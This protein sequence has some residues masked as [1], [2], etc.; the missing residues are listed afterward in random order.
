MAD[1][2]STLSLKLDG[3]QLSASAAKLRSELAALGMTGEQQRKFFG[4]S[5]PA[6]FK[7]TEQ[8]ANRVTDAMKRMRE[9]SAAAAMALQIRGNDP[10]Q[11]VATRVE[12]ANVQMRT[13]TQL[14]K[15]AAVNTGVLGRQG[16]LLANVI[17]ESVERFGE[18]RKAQVA[19]AAATGATVTTMTTLKAAI[20][21]INP[22]MGILLAG[23]A[24]Y[25]ITSKL[26]G[27][28]TD[29]LVEAAERNIQKQEKL[30]E[31]L[32]KQN[33]EWIA[34]ER[35]ASN[36]EARLRNV[37]GGGNDRE[38]A[39]RLAI[40]DR[41]MESARQARAA[42]RNPEQ[43]EEAAA[44]THNFLLREFNASKDLEAF[45]E[46]QGRLRAEKERLEELKA[47][48]LGGAA[49]VETL[50]R[51]RV[52]S[53]DA[54]K[55][56]TEDEVR[57][58]QA[59]VTYLE[60]LKRAS[61][62]IEGQNVVSAPLQ[63]IK[64]DIAELPELK[65]GIMEIRRTWMQ[66]VGDSLIAFADGFNEVIDTVHDSFVNMIADIFGT[67]VATNFAN[68]IGSALAPVLTSVFGSILTSVAS[69]FWGWLSGTGDHTLGELL[70]ATRFNRFG[71]LAGQRHR[72][73]LSNLPSTGDDL[74]GR[75]DADPFAKGG[76]KGV[77]PGAP[78]TI[79]TR[80]G[81]G[82]SIEQ[83]NRLIGLTGTMVALLRRIDTSTAK[84]ANGGVQLSRDMNDAANRS[85]Y[86]GGDAL[87][88]A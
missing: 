35:A 36:A 71:G 76:D 52:L 42:G 22:V 45:N 65:A 59:T 82:A 51:A 58:L 54:P 48:L 80:F 61:A 46:R 67:K 62:P 17:G 1:A 30:T 26:M 2:M 69:D 34:M 8:G 57:R 14:T 32:R 79:T 25:T 86:L 60:Q 23:M 16:F 44:R 12:G 56:V 77:V 66:T 5:L 41:A 38:F 72:F 29:E 21:S 28:N 85:R 15:E 75:Q 47:A 88:S 64:S 33:Q 24:A 9:Q 20:A 50:R 78:D 37:L 39:A 83:A 31:I 74:I 11:N 87:V 13:F 7:P 4:S 68:A 55:M 27:D 43:V 84:M 63:L 53:Q 81:A 10:F 19:T 6:A 73:R 3:T 49:A 18:L 70:D 40:F